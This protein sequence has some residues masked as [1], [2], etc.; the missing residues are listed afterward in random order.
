ML[1]YLCVLHLRWKQTHHLV[2]QIK[3]NN[4]KR[5]VKTTKTR[6]ERV[7]VIWS[8][9]TYLPLR[10]KSVLL[11]QP[12]YD[13]NL[14]WHLTFVY[15]TEVC[16]F[17]RKPVALSEPAIEALNRTYHDGCFQCR[18]CHTPLAG[19][20]YYNKA[21]IPLCEDCYQVDASQ[22]S[23]YCMRYSKLQMQVFLLRT[24]PVFLPAFS[25]IHSLTCDLQ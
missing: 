13:H 5:P 10:L 14:L 4:P 1:R 25:V 18:S 17:C 24:T 16:G 15:N 21:G 3:M 2:G 22:L 8:K 11:W 7:K 20:Q 19:K 12:T 23:F 6:T 9:F